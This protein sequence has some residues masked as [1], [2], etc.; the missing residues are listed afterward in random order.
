M[1]EVEVADKRPSRDVRCAKQNGRARG[2][3]HSTS[4]R[5]E[6]D[7]LR[8]G[9]KWLPHLVARALAAVA[10]LVV[11]GLLAAC[12]P[13]EVSE[14][15]ELEE[16][17]PPASAVA[18]ATTHV[19][20][21]PSDTFASSSQLEKGTTTP[22][23]S[24]APGTTTVSSSTGPPASIS[25]QRS[26]EDS[27]ETNTSTATVA[28]SGEG[29]DGGGTA[30]LDRD[31]PQFVLEP[32]ILHVDVDGDDAVI[33]SR[34]ES[35]TAERES[36]QRGEDRAVPTPSRGARFTWHDGDREALVWQD[37]RLV[38]SNVIAEGGWGDPSGPVFWSESNQ[39]MALP[40]GVVLMLDP[41]W[42][43][44]AVNA[45]MRSNNISSSRVDAFEGLNNAFKVETTPGFPSLRLAN[46]LAGQNG[47]LISSPNWWIKGLID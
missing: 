32:Q 17:A 13:Q 1:M 34:P 19:G 4:Q 28:A 23:E 7:T 44:A 10:V 42:G 22:T 30:T 20:R 45:F 3:G 15:P 35:D 33:I 29:L 38:V 27:D 8:R 9:W 18:P 39:L 40:G 46:S 12:G 2:D 47:V 24:A 14:R 21:L 37:T 41:S 6:P 5:V 36:A 31:E 25:E 11:A 16:T 43:A 26:G